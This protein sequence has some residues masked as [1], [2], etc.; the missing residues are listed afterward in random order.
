L[1]ATPLRPEATQFSPPFRVFVNRAQPGALAEGEM[2]G[3]LL[4]S[5]VFASLLPPLASTAVAEKAGVE[6]GSLLQAR[7]EVQ[8]SPRVRGGSPDIVKAL[9]EAMIGSSTFRQLI[10]DINATD[11]IVYVHRGICGR[12][13]LACLLLN[14]TKA[15]PN[16]ILH[17][18]VDPRKRG[19]DLIVTI[20]H[21]LS[22]AV[23]LLRNPGVVDA[24]SARL[25]YDLE[26]PTHRLAFETT[27]AIQ[28]ELQIDSEL[29]QWKKR[30]S[31]YE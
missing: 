24:K 21:E 8:G 22:Q 30:A 10:A 25:F 14:V 29:R 17:I 26:V 23:E 27:N 18:K 16:R 5:L 12:N 19:T 6:V 2:M 20:G 15:G 13:V 9:N 31:R 11:G 7:P 4:G 1:V 28:I 3:R